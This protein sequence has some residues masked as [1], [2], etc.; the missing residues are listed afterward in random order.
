MFRKLARATAQTYRLAANTIL[1]IVLVLIVANVG[2]YLFLRYLKLVQAGTADIPVVA[3]YGEHVRAAYP[4]WSAVDVNDLL[5]EIW[6]RPLVYESF[7]QFKEQAHEGRFVNVDEVGFRHVK[8]QVPWPPD[9]AAFNV[10]VF[11]GSTTFG[12]GVAD[13]GTVASFLQERLRR[14]LGNNVAVYNFGRGFYYSTHE[15]LLFIKLLHQGFVP[16]LAIF[17]DGF[18]DFHYAGAKD[19]IWTGSLKRSQSHSLGEIARSFWMET[20]FARALLRLSDRASR[21]TAAESNAADEAPDAESQRETTK[22]VPSLVEST[23]SRYRRNQSL[24]EG[25]ATAFAVPTIFVLQP[26]PSYRYD[27]THHPFYQAGERERALYQ[28]GFAAFEAAAARGVLGDNFLSCADIQ[29]GVTE[30]SYVDAVHYAPSLADRLSA[31]IVERSDAAGLLPD[32][33]P[34]GVEH[35]AERHRSPESE[36]LAQFAGSAP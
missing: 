24:I 23:L 33:A 36:Q 32:V 30:L 31:C 22:A 19:L 20:P 1:A 34:A 26:V 16:S 9:T 18:N 4:G 6:S 25:A 29:E 35:G 15:M 14:A 27:T 11:G 17:V 10:F 2:G 3:E 28:M 21:D 12:Y 8:D 13:E 7:T 5:Y